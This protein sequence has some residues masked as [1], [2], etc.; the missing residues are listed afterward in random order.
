AATGVD[1]LDQQLR[2]AT[3]R[4]LALN[5]DGARHAGIRFL[6]ATR[7]GRLTG[8]TGTAEAARVPGVESVVV[9]GA[10]GRAVRPPQDAY[11]RLG[12][13]LAVGAT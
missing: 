4:P 2:A 11:D 6:T 8:V 10:P 1:L 12:H 13:V 9:T 5:T 7:S 3:G